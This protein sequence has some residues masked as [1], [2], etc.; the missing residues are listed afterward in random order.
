M[1]NLSCRVRSIDYLLG[2]TARR[3]RG[4]V[5]LLVG[6]R[7]LSPVAVGVNGV[8][9]G[10]NGKDGDNGEKESLPWRHGCSPEPG[11]KPERR[12]RELL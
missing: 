9:G 5:D 4:G 8:A 10:G 3:Q 7:G 1:N 6:D 12:R 11:S 2:L